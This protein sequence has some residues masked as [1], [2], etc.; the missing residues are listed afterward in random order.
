MRIQETNQIIN[1]TNPQRLAR[2]R[3]ETSATLR[4][5]P[6]ALRGRPLVIG[7]GVAVAVGVGLALTRRSRKQ[8]LFGL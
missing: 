6:K 3:K 7:L 1:E 4:R 5:L 2:E 8:S